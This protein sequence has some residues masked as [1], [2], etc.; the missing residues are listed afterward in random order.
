MKSHAARTRTHLLAVM[1]MTL[2]VAGTIRN[3]TAGNA[4]EA[5]AEDKTALVLN[6]TQQSRLGVR[7]AAVTAAKTLDVANLSAEV[8]LPVAGTA[9]VAAPYA[10][11][12]VQVNVDEGQ[13]VRAGQALAVLSS[14]DY[15]TDH[16]LLHRRRAETEVADRQAGRDDALLD[17]GVIPR[18][19]AETSRSLATAL[20]AELEG[21]EAAVGAVH[22]DGGDATAFT[23]R[24]PIDGFIVTR[25]IQSS[26]QMQA[27][28]VAFVIARDAR[29]RLEVDVPIAVAG[30]VTPAARLRVGDL[31]IPVDGRGTTLD[32]TTQT[33][34]VRGTLP[35]D[36]G[37]LPGQRISAELRVP[38]PADSWQI[39]QGALSRAG[40]EAEI[41]VASRTDAGTSFSRLSVRVLAEDAR[42][43]VIAAP[44]QADS[45]VAIAGTSALKGL[46][47]P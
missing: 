15:A 24:A 21:L 5:A 32:P 38:A 7:T 25:S 6:P 30:Q 10:G 43:A 18:A 36:S 42:H 39:P 44:L 45:V 40:A 2:L 46:G 12:V 37:L 26:V 19:R 34:K 27:Q 41:F 23:L 13:T 20:K 29:W 11:R 14:R 8:Q 9:A 17:A 31:E 35:A 4:A 47:G 16:A 33:V 28:E 22:A 1:A 3:A